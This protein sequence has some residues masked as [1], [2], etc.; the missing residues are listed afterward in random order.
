MLFDLQGRRRRVVQGT[1]LMLAVLMGGGLVLFGIGGEVSGGLVDAFSGRSGGG[2]NGNQIIEERVDENQERL[3]SNPANE[4]PIRAE[5]VRDYYSLATSA[6]TDG[7]TFSADARADL[8]R[9]SENWQAYLAL[10]PERIDT[11]LAGL[12][13]Q[14]YDPNVLNRPQEAK[15]AAQLVAR[16]EEDVTSYLNLI[17]YSVLAGDTRTADLAAQRAVD[18]APR[19]RKQQVRQQAEQLKMPQTGQAGAPQGGSA[20]PTPTPAPAP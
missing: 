13:L 14:L 9:A 10:E 4:A 17:Q 2:G 7:Q 16:E 8:R 6:T 20:P 1:Y 12:A 11:S 5:L 19:S 18:L 3:A 15:E